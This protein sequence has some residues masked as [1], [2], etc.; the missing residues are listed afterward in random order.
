MIVQFQL[1]LEGQVARWYV[2]QDVFTFWTFQELVDKFLEMFQVKIDPTEV[3]KE[4]YSLQQQSGESVAD[5]L[6]R[7]R[8]VQ[9]MLDT[10]PTEE[11]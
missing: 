10:A 3:L 2:Q 8:V 4:Y 6:L 9:A 7:F 5:F 1:S 11:I